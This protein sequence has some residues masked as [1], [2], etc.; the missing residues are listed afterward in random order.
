MRYLP[1]ELS[2]RLSK[3]LE[4]ASKFGQN[5]HENVDLFM[6]KIVDELVIEGGQ[7][8]SSGISDPFSQFSGI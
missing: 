5:T 2:T 3:I 1:E 6:K 7:S 8:D 4:A